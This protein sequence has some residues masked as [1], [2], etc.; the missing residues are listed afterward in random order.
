MLPIPIDICKAEFQKV[1]CKEWKN[2]VCKKPKLRTYLT[3]KDN[4]EVEPYVKSFLNRKCRS[5]LAQYRCGILPIEI[6]TGRWI[7]KPLDSRVCLVCNTGCVESEEHII[8]RCTFHD[9]L[10]ATFIDEA[11]EYFPSITQLTMTEQLKL[12]MDKPLVNS[13]AQLISDIMYHRNKKLFNDN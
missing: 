9:K 6:E 4:F 8:F 5:Y 11:K 7:N 10:R 3:F 1:L 12:F 13:F 2:D